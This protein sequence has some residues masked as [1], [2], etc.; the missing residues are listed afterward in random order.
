MQVTIGALPLIVIVTVPFAQAP[1]LLQ[2][3]YS[4]A[5]VAA[6]SVASF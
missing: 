4:N 5:S 1:W 3:S 2:A 6:G